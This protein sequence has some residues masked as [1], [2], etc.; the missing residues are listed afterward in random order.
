MKQQRA[1]PKQ[2]VLNL[3]EQV[4][5]WGVF[6]LVN[7]LWVVL[8]IPLI[9]MPAA[10]AGLFAVMTR[11]SRGENPELFQTFFSA[12]R[13]Y[14]VKATL[15][16]ALNLAA[17]GL[18]VLNLTILPFMSGS[19]P[20]AFLARSVTLFAGI[21]LILVNFYVWALLVQ[22]DMPLQQLITVSIRFVFMYPVWTLG[23]LLAAVL[24]ILIS[25]I[26]P[27]AVFLLVTVSAIAW[28]ICRGTWHV[29]RQHLV[30]DPNATHMTE[31]TLK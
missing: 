17:G 19:D 1:N 27:Q 22:I 21:M 24:P 16:M 25:W 9:T 6:V 8:S 14:A 30:T 13:R 28:I 20:I 10:T 2:D 7:L 5:K 3:L 15:L 29:I 11:W 26:L 4:D 18:I 23:I 12:M 31:P